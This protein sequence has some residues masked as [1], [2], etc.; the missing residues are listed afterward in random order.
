LN[1]YNNTL[2][3]RN[4]IEINFLII[5]IFLYLFRSSI[6]LFKYPFLLFISCFSIYS[7]IVYRKEVIDSLKKYF[8]TY[9]LIFLLVIVFFISIW[10]SKKLYL[11]L[12]KESV[13]ILILLLLFFLLTLIVS[14]KSKLSLF[15]SN[16]LF[17]V[18]IFA[19]LIA[20]VNT[21]FFIQ[22][23]KNFGYY[24]VHSHQDQYILSSLLLDRNFA[25]LP[26]FFGFMILLYKLNNNVS[27]GER[28]LY[29]LLLLFFSIHIFISL[30]RRGQIV[31]LLIVAFTLAL[32]ICLLLNKCLIFK[33]LNSNIAIFHSLIFIVPLFTILFIHFGSYDFKVNTLK[34]LK[35]KNISGTKT[36]ITSILYN[37]VNRFNGNLSYYDFNKKLWSITFNPR[38]P[39]NGWGIGL[40]KTT[41]PLVG[42]NVDIVPEG[43]TGNLLDSLCSFSHSESHAY[44]NTMFFDKIVSKND[45]IKSSVYCYASPDF[46]GDQICLRADGTSYGNRVSSYDL[47]LK[48]RW[49]RLAIAA[50]CSTGE[51]YLS[52]YFN[53]Q[54]VTDF[55][56]LTGYVIFAY[57]EYKLISNDSLISNHLKPETNL[58][59]P[60][61]HNWIKASLLS[62]KSNYATLFD[63]PLEKLIPQVDKYT[64]SDP[65]RNWVA[66]I[67]S[68]DSTY[69]PYRA[70]LHVN[71]HSTRLADERISRWKFA[72]QIFVKE[73]NWKERIFGGGFSFLNWYGYYF[74]NDKTR[75]DY[76]HNPLLHILLY[77]GILGLILYIYVMYRVLYYYLLYIKEYYM[78]FIFFI[79]AYFFTFFSGGNPFDPHI[80]G[81][82]VIL[83]FFIN[84]VHKNNKSEIDKNVN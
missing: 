83:P 2:S 41:F 40:Y 19:L 37:Y 35:V 16:L 81:F 20:L 69:Y 33:R 84:S 27:K 10:F 1:T 72:L 51:A 49:Q 39:D 67:I 54:G 24:P 45:T 75:S 55:S 66:R 29:N 11:S 15:Q 6:P 82:F 58:G 3:K 63:F 76:P 70:N 59:K 43:S 77:S 7:L 36:V 4:H 80:T 48:G 32:R 30:S 64:G 47:N 44:S 62:E 31:L 52:F 71:I 9:F 56:K 42:D 60:V 38:D 28:I 78:I 57:P 26:V 22:I 61:N 13:D 65:I 73:Y 25:L 8:K 12:F 17:I 23:Q 74:Y 46:N 18:L 68:E 14:S 34:F 21:Y 53:K 50:S 79:I 5:T